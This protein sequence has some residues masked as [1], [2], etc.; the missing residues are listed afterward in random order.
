M[1][2]APA[3]CCAARTVRTIIVLKAAS[4]LTRCTA[5]TGAQLLTLGLLLRLTR[6]WA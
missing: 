2:L 6:P 3:A 4:K 1:L 5:R